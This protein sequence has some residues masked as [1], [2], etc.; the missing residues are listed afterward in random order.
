MTVSL[1]PRGG[2]R[3]RRR[4]LRRFARAVKNLQLNADIASGE[5]ERGD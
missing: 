1:L 4:R 5:F 2:W 3:S